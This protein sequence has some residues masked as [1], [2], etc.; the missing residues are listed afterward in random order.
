MDYNEFGKTFEADRYVYY[1]NV[2]MFSWMY[3]YIETCNYNNIVYC[4]SIIPQ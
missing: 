4:M 3:I 2:S 1:L